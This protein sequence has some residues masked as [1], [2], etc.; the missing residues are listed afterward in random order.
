MLALGILDRKYAVNLAFNVSLRRFL[1]WLFLLLA[2]C[3]CYLVVD[4]ACVLYKRFRF[5]GEL[6]TL[7]GWLPS[8]ANKARLRIAVVYPKDFPGEANVAQSFVRALR[9]RNIA[10]YECL[11]SPSDPC[12]RAKKVKRIQRWLNWALNTDTAV[13]L[14]MRSCDRGLIRA[15]RHYISAFDSCPPAL[16]FSL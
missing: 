9:A 11:V 14:F 13:V 6:Q 12:Q 10:V 15:R 2:A 5:H 7:S 16:Y 8:T 4:Y 3:G 1:K